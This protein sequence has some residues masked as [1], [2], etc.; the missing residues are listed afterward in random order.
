MIFLQLEL[1]LI[2][3][4]KDVGGMRCR[5]SGGV[6]PWELLELSVSEQGPIRR[7]GQPTGR[8]GCCPWLHRE[9]GLSGDSG[10]NAVPSLPA[11][12]LCLLRL[13]AGL[14]QML[15]RGTWRCPSGEP[16]SSTAAPCSVHGSGVAPEKGEERPH[17]PGSAPAFHRLS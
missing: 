6:S 5:F 4:G 10:S 16:G 12:V 9:L 13:L 1:N 2:S 8:R 11:P 7:R 17:L 14:E 3:R 15:Q